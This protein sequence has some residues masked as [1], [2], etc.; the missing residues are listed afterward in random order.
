MTKVLERAE[1]IPKHNKGNIQQA[2]SQHQIK[3]KLKAF[4]LKSGPRQG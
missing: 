2:N 1:I 4:T 3:W